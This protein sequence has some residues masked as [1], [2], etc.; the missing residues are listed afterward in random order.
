MT[1]RAMRNFL[2]RL[3]AWVGLNIAL[4]LVMIFSTGTFLVF[5]T[6][7]EGFIH[8]GMR[9]PVATSQRSA[10]AGEIY[11]TVRSTYP[12][13]TIGW[14][15][16]E[17][18]SWIGDATV[19]FPKWG[20]E[21]FVWT[22][23]TTTEV[24][25]ATRRSG[26]LKMIV[27]QLHD[28]LLTGHRLGEILITTMS[29]MLLI[30]IITGLVT[31]RRFWRGFF[32][33]PPRH[34]GARGW[35]A[36]LH[37]LTALWS[38]PFLIVVCLT[39]FYYFIT[40]LGVPLGHYPAPAAA[41]ERSAKLPA[42]FS[43]ADLDRAATVAKDA[44]PD[45]E[46]TAIVLPNQ[47]TKGI[48][49]AGHTDALLAEVKAN[50]VVIDP[51]TFEPLGAYHAAELGP[52]TRITSMIEPLHYGVWGGFA[53][54]L[55]W[56]VFGVLATGVAIFGVMVYASRI[57]GAAGN[58]APASG[59]FRRA[60]R[61]MSPLKWLVALALAGA[62]AVGIYRFVLK[63]DRWVRQW[64]PEPA[65]DA[66]LWTRG[67]L[68]A[69]DAIELRFRLTADGARQA[70]VQLGNGAAESISLKQTGTTLT[71]VITLEA[72]TSDNDVVLT[73]P[74]LGEGGTILKWR[75]GRPIL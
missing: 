46:I 56:L 22:D 43:G 27:R 47:A 14:I 36:G 1:S 50:T 11:D 24:L 53:S 4:L 3:H 68:H 9:A 31:Y 20:G 26:G 34:Q 19:V 51:V 44:L 23:P 45:F 33:M 6:E 55:L 69:G 60:W 75:L 74:G 72:D 29:L 39:G 40:I 38:L 49:F 21:I 5:I 18:A 61:G 10:T 65:H 8:K 58:T 62:V 37:R 41:T 35:W 7:I 30:S 71:S 16:R 59:P 66:R 12:D 48:S 13:A 70:T 28:S 63:D 2:F 64:Q 52:L 73:I 54:R 32:R 15:E 25:G 17:K 42:G 67:E 57:L